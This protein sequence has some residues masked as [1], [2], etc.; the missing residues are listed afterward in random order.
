MSIYTCDIRILRHIIHRDFAIII[1]IINAAAASSSPFA[2]FFVKF[3]FFILCAAVAA[4]V[5]VL[6]I[7]SWQAIFISI[8]AAEH[9]AMIYGSVSY[10]AFRDSR[11][12]AV[13][14]VRCA[15]TSSVV[16]VWGGC[17]LRRRRTIRTRFAHQIECISS[18]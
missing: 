13:V 8:P 17:R 12:L 7:P 14:G 6:Y 10:P 15:T 2:C 16:C 1:A 11:H 18:H 9:S 4:A 5:V 3:S